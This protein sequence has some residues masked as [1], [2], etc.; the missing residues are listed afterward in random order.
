MQ[1]FGRIA[2]EDARLLRV[3]SRSVPEDIL[4][5]HGGQHALAPLQETVGIRGTN[6][7]LGLRIERAKLQA[8]QPEH[9]PGFSLL[10]AFF[11]DLAVPTV[12]AFSQHGF[13]LL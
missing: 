7:V 3:P 4:E 8:E 13:D 6:P 10:A 5:A 11:S 2:A 1:A 12:N 9:Q